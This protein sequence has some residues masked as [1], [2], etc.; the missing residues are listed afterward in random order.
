MTSQI[1]GPCCDLDVKTNECKSLVEKSRSAT[2]FRRLWRCLSLKET[3][4]SLV[5]ITN[6]LKIINACQDSFKREKKLYRWV[7]LIP[8]RRHNAV[9]KIMLKCVE[10]RAS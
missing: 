1:S 3:K 6:I 9:G 5:S 4:S 7:V 10:S 2:N 8:M